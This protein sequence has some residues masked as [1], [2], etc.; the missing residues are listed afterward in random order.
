MGKPTLVPFKAQ[1]LLAIASRNPF[2]DA[3]IDDAW[4]KEAKGPGFTAIVND[5]PLACAGV[6]IVRPGVGYAWTVFSHDITNYRL[7]VTRTIR[8]TL[9]NI[10]K[11]CN[12][13]RVEALVA[14]TQLG[15]RRWIESL[16][17]EAEG[18]AHD[19][20]SDR[21]NVVRYEWVRYKV[22]IVEVGDRNIRQFVARIDDVDVGY[23]V[24][25]YTPEMYAY[26]AQ[27]EVDE[28][29]RGRGIGLMLH[30]ARLTQA[31][32]DGASHFVGRTDNPKMIRILVGCGARRCENELGVTYVVKL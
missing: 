1:H 27:C 9:R 16:G 24:H 20:T 19:Y 30:K 21:R 22:R 23:A 3:L 5:K 15:N 8:H 10:I 28:H 6:Q 4:Q 12:L 14:E 25:A 7:F 18:V 11:G 13:H 32:V 31:R 29:Y 17:F 2:D 26:G